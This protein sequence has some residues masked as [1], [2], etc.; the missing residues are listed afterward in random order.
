MRMKMY[1]SEFRQISCRQYTGAKWILSG[2]EK[3]MDKENG[4]TDG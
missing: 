2:A 3:R 4:K 1:S